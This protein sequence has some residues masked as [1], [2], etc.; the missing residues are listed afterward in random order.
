MKLI[1]TPTG[2]NGEK[3][4]DVIIIGGGPAGLSAGIYSARNNLKTLILE[5]EIIGGQIS[6][7]DFVDDYP[8]FPEGV[9]PQTLINR[10]EEHARKFGS[11][12]LFEEV[13]EINLNG[14]YKIVKTFSNE[15]KTKALIIATG[16]RYKELNVP[17]EKKFMGKGVSYCAVCDGPLFR[18][19]DMVVIGGRYAA[20][21]EAIYLTRFAK[22]VYLIHDEDKLRVAKIYL[23]KLSKN[24]KIEILLERRIKEIY[25]K[26]KVEGIT[27][28][29]IKT[30]EIQKLPCSAVFV[31]IGFVP[32]TEFLRGI[33]KLDP[34]GAVVVNEKMETNVPGIYAAGDVRI[35]SFRQI[36][37][38]A[39]DGVTAAI[40]A[41]SYIEKEF[42]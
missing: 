29:N 2:E 37:T 42:K 21:K 30:K 41:E 36:V 1:F 18:E 24:P 19:K 4:Y 38:A 16:V 15:Y 17:G 13:K 5:K 39:S 6:K 27:F 20:V 12:I 9:D 11:K 23:E 34:Q 40:S 28:E 25:G 8:G 10:F 14:K 3:E 26:E 32:N 7:T 22:K 31:Y 35:Y 33:V